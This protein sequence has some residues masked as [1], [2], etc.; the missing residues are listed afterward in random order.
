[1]SDN[2]KNAEEAL[3]EAKAALDS[4]NSATTTGST[5]QIV[6]QSVVALLPGDL[7]ITEKYDNALQAVIKAEQ[8]L[9]D[10]RQKEA[11]TRASNFA[12]SSLAMEQEL[13]LLRTQAA[14]GE[15]SAEAKNLAT[16]QELDNRIAAIKAQRVSGELDEDQAN[17]L[18]LRARLAAEL[19]KQ[20]EENNTLEGIREEI[21]AREQNLRLL[22][23]ERD[24]TKD[25]H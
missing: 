9:A 19:G 11:D 24:H 7:S 1:M 18:K 4:L 17:Y 25:S 8:E 16:Q 15:D 21:A 23:I 5:G 20:I 2:V 14:F 12:K 10:L 13:E 22:E 3:E 6:F